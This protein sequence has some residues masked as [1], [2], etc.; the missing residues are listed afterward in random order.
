MKKIPTLFFCLLLGTCILSA[1][2]ALIINAHDGSLEGAKVHSII[3]LLDNA[4]YE[5][6]WL[7]NGN[8]TW[9]L[10]KKHAQGVNIL[11][12]AG[13]GSTLGYN[14]TGGLCLDNGNS[15]DIRS[16]FEV[17][18]NIQLAPNALVLFKSVCGGAG[19]SADDD[20]DIGIKEAVNR[21]N[22]YSQPFFNMG[23]A[24]YYADNWDGGLERF[25]RLLFQ[26]YTI[27]EAYRE[28]ASTWN[29]LDYTGWSTYD[30]NVMIGVSSNYRPGT[31]KRT[32]TRNGVTTVETLSNFKKYSVAYAGKKDFKIR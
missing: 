3:D 19:S 12:Y 32:S 4:G 25:L 7:G 27:D 10:V 31:F 8:A 23:A 18:E 15:T 26:G 6:T 5:V 13:H 11:I 1:Q 14:G 30:S 20:G 2:R 24:G 28:S 9:D 29:D 21:V 16:S 17:E 22:S